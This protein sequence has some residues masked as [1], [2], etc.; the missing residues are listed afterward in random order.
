MNRFRR[1]FL[2]GLLVLAPPVVS[3][4]VLYIIGG[5]LDKLLGGIFRGEFIRPGGIP[6]LGLLS[7]VLIITLVGMLASNILGR[8]VV[9]MWER[10]LLS[11]PI[12]NRVFTGAKQI[13]EAIFRQG[14]GT[15]RQVVLVEFPRKGMYSVGFLTGQAAQELKRKSGEDL[16]SVFL[17]TT[18]NPTSGYLL[19]VPV[20]DVMRLEMSVEDGLK[21]A[22][23]AG[24]YMPGR[25]Q[26]EAER[27]AERPPAR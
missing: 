5:K 9:G 19:L 4:Y 13:A 8:R 20:A 14:S 6:G 3:F 15:F 10:L 23:S 2:T 25:D 18:P 21:L 1:Y 24:S 11:I 7:L 27:P 16:V 22:I 17:P 26:P 12:L